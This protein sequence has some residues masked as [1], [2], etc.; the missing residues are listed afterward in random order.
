MTRTTARTFAKILLLIALG[1]VI[2]WLA[3]PKKNPPPLP[4][5]Q[6]ATTAPAEVDGAH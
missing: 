4:A 1:A 2:L 5:D 3:C 6:E